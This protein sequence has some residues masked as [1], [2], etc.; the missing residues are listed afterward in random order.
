MVYGNP[1]VAIMGTGCLI[2][3]DLRENFRLNLEIGKIS[4]MMQSLLYIATTVGL[5]VVSHTYG[6]WRVVHHTLKDQ[7][8]T[9]VVVSAGTIIVGSS[10][11]LWRSIDGGH[12]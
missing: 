8:L 12:A 1:V 6:H 2:A 4:I 9:G 7:S 5:A 3:V 10:H 11:G